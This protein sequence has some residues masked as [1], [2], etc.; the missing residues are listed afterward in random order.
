MQRSCACTWVL[1][2]EEMA[3]KI[4][5]AQINE[6]RLQ[7]LLWSTGN[8]TSVSWTIWVSKDHYRVSAFDWPWICAIFDWAYWRVS[9]PSHTEPSHTVARLWKRP[10]NEQGNR[11]PKY[12]TIYDILAYNIIPIQM[13]IPSNGSMFA[14]VELRRQIVTSQVTG[15]LSSYF[16]V[17]TLALLV[18]VTRIP[19]F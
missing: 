12:N 13:I 10:V 11:I 1:R 4:S 2:R 15:C 17:Q 5:V 14:L 6:W 19:H 9:K 18:V 8:G 3:S 7:R 16:S